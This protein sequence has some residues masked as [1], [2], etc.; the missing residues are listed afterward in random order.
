M[1][2]P[3]RRYHSYLLRIWCEE[4]ALAIH[5]RVSLISADGEER[6]GFPSLEAAY[7]FLRAQMQAWEEE[8]LDSLD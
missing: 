6:R 1:N 2:Q 8:R 5:W 3:A 4:S 7:A